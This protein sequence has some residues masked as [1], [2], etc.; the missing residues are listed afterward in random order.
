[1]AAVRSDDAD[2][3]GEIVQIIEVDLNKAH[4]IDF[5]MFAA[6]RRDSVDTVS[7]LLQTRRYDVNRLGHN[8]ASILHKAVMQGCSHRI[9]TLI[10]NCERVDVNKRDQNGYAP[11]HFLVSWMCV[12]RS[13]R[14]AKVSLRA[15][16]NMMALVSHERVDNDVKDSTERTAADIAAEGGLF[17]LA[18]VLRKL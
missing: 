17:G 6:A 1:M 16:D 8:G 3:F 14:E 10:L 12:A 5:V 11:L 13:R 9:V 7:L 4:L 15:W 18:N 2:T